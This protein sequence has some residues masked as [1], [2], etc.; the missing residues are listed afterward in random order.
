[1]RW[2]ILLLCLVLSKPALAEPEVTV[3]VELVLAVDVSRSMT[4]RELEIQRRG[5]AE[6]LVSDAVIQAI[7]RGGLGR[8][9]VTYVE[10]AGTGS[11]QIV[12]EWALIA[13]R[14]DAEIF[15]ARLTAHFVDNMR[16]TSISGALDYA[17]SLFR[18]NGFRGDRWPDQPVGLEPALRDY[19][20]AVEGLAASLRRIFM[21]A[22]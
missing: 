14:A 5:Y 7:G 21:A 18:R 3:D 19:Y 1:M 8:V 15:A 4:A 22:T 11:Q 17:A 2:L 16:R 6:A 10:W 9:A 20:R 12:V 13:G